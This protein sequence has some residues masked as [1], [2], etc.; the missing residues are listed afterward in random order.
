MNQSQLETL[1]C[2]IC[3]EY[4]EEAVISSCCNAV[5]CRNCVANLNQCPI[6][7]AVH[8]QFNEA[9]LA[10]RLINMIEI[11]CDCGYKCAR[12]ELSTHKKSCVNSVVKCPFE[13]CDQNL[14]IAECYQHIKRFHSNMLKKPP[15]TTN[16]PG[17][18]Q[19]STLNENVAKTIFL[20]FICYFV[21][22]W[23]YST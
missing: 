4:S 13:V 21:Y 15:P 23:L 19:Q 5:Y 11:R 20:L 7:R 6:C 17:R 8:C 18:V 2:P 9:I 1:V 14:K 3:L 10:R 22:Y 12:V 16:Q